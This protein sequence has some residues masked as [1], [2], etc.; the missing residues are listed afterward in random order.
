MVET[1]G[2][3]TGTTTATEVWMRGPLRRARKQLRQKQ[4]QTEETEGMRDKGGG[5][6]REQRAKAGERQAF[7]KPEMGNREPWLPCEP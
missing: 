5:G 3:A 6:E 7:V 1:G 4:Q 2:V